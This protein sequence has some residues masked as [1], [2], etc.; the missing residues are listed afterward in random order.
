MYEKINE[1]L[2]KGFEELAPDMFDDFMKKEPVRIETE[3]ELLGTSG[4]SSRPFLSMKKILTASAIAAVILLAVL[5]VLAGRNRVVDR[6][7]MDVNPSV[8]ILLN[9]HGKVVRIE[10]ANDD[11]KRVA[12]AILAEAKKIKAPAEAVLLVTEEMNREGYF[13]VPNA[14]LLLSYCYKEK[15]KTQLVASISESLQTYAEE[16]D[17]NE[18]LIVQSFSYDKDQVKQ[19]DDKG[20]SPGKYVLI[21]NLG[22]GDADAAAFSEDFDQKLD[23][24]VKNHGQALPQNTFIY[25][26]EKKEAVPEKDAE[27]AEEPESVTEPEDGEEIKEHSDNSSNKNKNN[28][29]KSEEKKAQKKEKKSKEKKEKKKENSS[30][31]QSEKKNNSSKNNSSNNSSSNKNQSGQNGQKSNSNASSSKEKKKG[32]N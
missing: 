4:K 20:I 19:S 5:G 17:L 15:E 3:A 18:V 12:E 22:V 2:N 24:Y 32:G 1:K 25:V 31:N 30:G 9:R 28:K 6:I 27:E 16:H 13:D 23:D 14:H 8:S 10:G 7:Y 11:G 21:K 26:I 29:G